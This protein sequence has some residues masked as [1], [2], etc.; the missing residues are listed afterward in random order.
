[1]DLGTKSN[2][3]SLEEMT[4]GVLIHG[5]G[6]IQLARWALVEAKR[7]GLRLFVIDRYGE[8]V[9]MA[10]A[11]KEMVILRPVSRRFNPL[12][13]F[14]SPGPSVLSLLYAAAFSVGRDYPR[15][16][17]VN[18]A[19][20][21]VMAGKE[22]TGV[23]LAAE[24]LELEIDELEV[25]VRPS[26]ISYLGG[27]EDFDMAAIIRQDVLV[28]M[29][30]VTATDEATLICLSCLVRAKALLTGGVTFLLIT[31]PD[32]FFS[33]RGKPSPASV[34]FIHDLL[35]SLQSSGIRLVL[36]CPSPKLLPPPVNERLRTQV[37]ERSW[38]PKIVISRLGDR[39]S[40]PSSPHY[41]SQAKIDDDEV[42]RRIAPFVIRES[43]KALPP[44]LISDFGEQAQLASDLVKYIG[45]KRPSLEEAIRWANGLA[46]G[47]GGST[48]GKLA[49]LRY[50]AV[51][52]AEAGASM[53][54]TEKGERA[55]SFVTGE[56]P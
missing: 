39:R 44:W 20:E 52:Q 46:K 35:A 55:L 17:L 2:G 21:L 6:L 42:E 3:L 41:Q 22:P 27:R 56:A 15:T 11:I 53:V 1:M 16:E 34:H 54:L 19:Q 10:S 9:G 23:S 13:P 45:E 50:A 25:L 28:D 49:R 51:V 14:G 47:L 4:S 32:I 37:E 8:L 40:F 12:K 31:H 26:S 5:P 48:V 33:V 36:A 30:S 43:E 7:H 18:R 38:P 24:L 29:S